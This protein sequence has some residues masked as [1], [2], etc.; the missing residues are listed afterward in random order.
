M[1][2]YNLDK[3][4]PAWLEQM[5]TKPNLTSS[6]EPDLTLKQCKDW[7]WSVPQCV[8]L[9]YHV[10]QRKCHV[11]RKSRLPELHN[12]ECCIYMEK[13][14][15]NCPPPLQSYNGTELP[16]SGDGELED[17][18]TSLNSTNL[19]EGERKDNTSDDGVKLDC[20]YSNVNRK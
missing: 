4:C 16:S 7:C 19:S 3:L 6:G 1:L 10:S 14:N 2:C 17:N 15:R 11:H 20:N 12:D 18:S 13:T 8:A 5:E 9:T